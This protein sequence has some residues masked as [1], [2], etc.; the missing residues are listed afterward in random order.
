MFSGFAF[1]TALNRNLS[2]PWEVQMTMMRETMI[3]NG[4][5]L[6]SAVDQGFK[7][8]WHKSANFLSRFWQKA[9]S[10]MSAPYSEPFADRL[11]DL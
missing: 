11:T 4:G 6:P 5:N 2:Q 7:Q 10:H 8:I 3:I 1:E 9:I